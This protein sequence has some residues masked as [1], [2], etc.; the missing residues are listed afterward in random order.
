[1]QDASAPVRRFLRESRRY[2]ALAAMALLAAGAASGQPLPP[3]DHTLELPHAGMTR[4]Y[5][6]HL[7]AH[8]DGASLPVVLNFHGGGGN[9]RSHQEYVRMDAVADREGFAVAYPAGTGTFKHRLLTWNAGTCCGR[10]QEKEID[11][12]AFVR[13]VVED[14]ARRTPIDR[15]RIYATGLS[16]GAMMAYRLAMEAPDLVAAIA[17]VAGASVILPFAPH[18]PVPIMHIHSVDDPRALYGG[19]LG[20]PFPFTSARVLHPPV[21]ETL[22]RWREANGCPDAARTDTP[23]RGGPGLQHTATR[24]TWGP[25]REETEVVLWK[26][27][28][29]GHVWPGGKPNYLTRVLG[30]S[31]DVI[32]ANVEMW[33]F[34]SRFSRRTPSR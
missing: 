4:S 16:N 24:Y 23:R 11:D 13:A 12:V 14:L 32:D 33:R 26:L 15:D 34:F 17:P 27:T 30:A 28:G 3:G 7:P 18:H 21:E 6:L 2:A 19:G 8:A 31:T 10:A 5:R 20:P 1:M 29:A 9:A 25:C 22:A